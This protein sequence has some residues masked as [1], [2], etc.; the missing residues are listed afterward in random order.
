MRY[1]IATFLLAGCAG[2]VQQER[3]RFGD[4]VVVVKGMYVDSRFTVQHMV[5]DAHREPCEGH[6]YYGM[7]QRSSMVT[8]DFICQEELGGLW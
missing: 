7:L 2:R 5:H 1:L 3:Y 6:Q 8:Y 4:T